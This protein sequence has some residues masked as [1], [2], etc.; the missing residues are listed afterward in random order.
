MVLKGREGGG[1]GVLSAVLKGMGAT[2]GVCCT[3]LI[4]PIG[5]MHYLCIVWCKCCSGETQ[6][7]H[8]AKETPTHIILDKLDDKPSHEAIIVWT[9]TKG[10]MN[11]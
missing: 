4:R 2:R 8:P 1:R 5:S 6:L 7:H 9:K 3:A 11:E 10:S